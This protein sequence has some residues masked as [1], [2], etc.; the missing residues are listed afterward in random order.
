VSYS[1]VLIVN[2]YSGYT[3]YTVGEWNETKQNKHN[4]ILLDIGLMCVF[5]TVVVN[6]NQAWNTEVSSII[7]GC[8]NIL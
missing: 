8:Y 2:T 7:G 3:M 1:I 4:I 6:K 5:G